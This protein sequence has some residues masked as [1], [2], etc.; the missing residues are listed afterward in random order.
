MIGDPRFHCGR[1]AQR[2]MNPTEIV[3]SVPKHD[4][5]P[6]TL[7]PFAEA[8][9][10]LREAPNSHSQAEIAP[11][12]YRSADAFRIG[13][14]AT[15]TTSTDATMFLSALSESR[16]RGILQWCGLQRGNAT[17]AS[18]GSTHLQALPSVRRGRQL[19]II[20]M[21]RGATSPATEAALSLW[22]TKQIA[23]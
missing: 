20:R 7:P 13:C 15:G 21:I 10:Q 8:M 2:P 1:N 14:P 22:S 16:S 12:D 19:G 3:I 11:L 4:S 17:L 9:R 18:F 23:G 6:V 5:S